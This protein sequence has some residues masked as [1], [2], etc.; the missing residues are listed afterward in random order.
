MATLPATY[1][2][3]RWQFSSCCIDL[4]QTDLDDEAWKILTRLAWGILFSMDTMMMSFFLYYDWARA[5][6]F[7][8][9]ST[10]PAGIVLLFKILMLVGSTL[11]MFVLVPPILLSSWQGL[12]ERRISTDTLIAIGSLSGY[13]ASL[14]SFAQGGDVYFDTATT[15]LVFVTA[16]HYLE[17]NARARGS[18]SLERLLTRAPDI[19][20]VIR[21]GEEKEVPASTIK[22]NETVIVRPGSSIAVDAVVAGGSGSV[23]ESSI[24]GEAELVFKEPGDTVYSGTVNVDGQLTLRATGVGEDRVMAK[25]VRLLR[26]ALSRRA[27]VQRLAD[28]VSSIF[29]PL[30][31]ISALIA[32]VFW[33][34][35]FDSSQGLLVALAVL[36]IACP[37]A[38]GVATPLAIW[39]GMGRAAQGGVLIRSA[40]ALEKLANVKAV[41]FDKTGTLTKGTLKLNEI[42]AADGIPE[43]RIVSLAA[44]LESA[45][46]HSLGRAVIAYA[47]K[48]KIGTHPV[49]NFKA[50]AGLGIVGQVANLTNGLDSVSQVAN[51]TNGLGIVGQVS[52][53]TL[54][55]TYAIGSARFM[56]RLNINNPLRAQKEKL[57]SQGRTV[58]CVAWQ[59][60]VRGLLGFS[61]AVRPESSSVIRDLINDGIIVAAL[62]GDDRSAAEA[63]ANQLN[64][65]VHANLLPQ[66]KQI[67]ISAAQFK[68]GT[69]AMVGDGLN[70][71]PALA[72]ADV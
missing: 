52:N 15:I 57:E 58:V 45:S 54:T 62:T 56:D 35:N 9:G 2:D 37:C 22:L 7:G 33:S 61:E 43:E 34:L 25:L 28:Q 20:C 24:T 30:T 64:I 46:E 40:E 29:V 48:N 31:V 49:K 60:D 66:D 44:S 59:G 1:A 69:V 18:E 8:G 16:G 47:L 3:T 38:L 32:F 26:E 53:L 67:L 4:D 41:F 27:P 65:R 12:R 14:Y 36:L 39:A 10:I 68:Y 6:I 13:F 72:R 50:H 42:I 11:T 21:D 17:L 63:L 70:D 51:L 5:L 71:A 19:A 55:L 23:N